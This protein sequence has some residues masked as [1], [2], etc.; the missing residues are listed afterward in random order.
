MDNK[1]SSVVIFQVDC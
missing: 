1:T